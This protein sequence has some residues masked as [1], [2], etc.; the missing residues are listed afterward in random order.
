[1][2]RTMVEVQTEYQQHAAV[3]GQV[4]YQISVLEEESRKTRRN[5]RKLNLEARGIQLAAENAAAK[6]APSVEAPAAE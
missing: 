6:E 5:M 2:S 3:L 4:T 1:M